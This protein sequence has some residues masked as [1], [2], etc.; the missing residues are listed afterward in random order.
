M[1]GRSFTGIKM[2]TADINT[3]DYGGKYA[4]AKPY[5]GA[6]LVIG[7]NWKNVMINE[8][9]DLISAERAELIWN[10]VNKRLKE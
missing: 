3:V 1:I 7:N 9:P 8:N 4:L 10:E 2:I 5:L 6:T